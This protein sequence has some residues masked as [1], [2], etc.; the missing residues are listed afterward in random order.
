MKNKIKISSLPILLVLL[1]LVLGACNKNEVTVTKDAK[2]GGLVV[3]VTANF[4]YKLANTP[5]VPIELTVPAGPTIV[6]I[7]V[8]NTFYSTNDTASSNQVLMSTVTS[9]SASLTFTLTYADLKKDLLVKGNPLPDDETLLGI[10]SYWTLNYTAV[11]SDGRRVVNNA[12]TTISVA[13]I[14]AGNYQ[15]VGIFH[16]PTAGDRPIN[17]EKFLSA[18]SAYQ[19]TSTTGDLGA[20]YPL[21]ITVNST[22]NSCTVA[23]LDPNPYDLL[24]TAGQN[25][26]YDPATGVFYLYYYYVGG[27]GLSRVIEETYTPIP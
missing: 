20:D 26:R 1:L 14:Y 18:I 27:N 15:C 21:V 5:T 9:I 13:N 25:S 24:M 8:Y 19:V 10:G 3:P 2:E 11:M 22:D 17:E 4:P 6:S 23:K 7:E 12:K 16:H